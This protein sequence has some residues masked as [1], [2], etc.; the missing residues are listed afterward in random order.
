MWILRLPCPSNDLPDRRG[1]SAKRTMIRGHLATPRR[2]L[3]APFGAPSTVF[4]ISLI[5][6]PIVAIALRAALVVTARFP[7]FHE[8]WIRGTIL[9]MYSSSRLSLLSCQAR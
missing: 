2:H 8:G 3:Y 9:R 6:G 4:S 7:P 5:L 1:T